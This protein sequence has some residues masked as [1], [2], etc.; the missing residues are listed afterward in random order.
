MQ[1]V[2]QLVWL[3][4]RLCRTVG[5]MPARRGFASRSLR[6]ATGLTQAA[7]RKAYKGVANDLGLLI[8]SRGVT[9]TF[10]RAGS[11]RRDP[12]ARLSGQGSKRITRRLSQRCDSDDAASQR[13]VGTFLPVDQPDAIAKAVAPFAIDFGCRLPCHSACP[14]AGPARARCRGNCLA[15][16]WCLFPQSYRTM[17]WRSRLSSVCSGTQDR[18]GDARRAS[19]RR[20]KELG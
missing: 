17:R 2:C 5:P 11:A 16:M 9:A 13:P 15:R 8:G 18:D 1:G 10:D 4:R 12:D 6:R 7:T 20:A 19:C 14:S 3:G